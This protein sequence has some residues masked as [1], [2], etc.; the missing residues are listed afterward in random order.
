MKYARL[1]NG[2]N[3]R[4]FPKKYPHQRENNMKMHIGKEGPRYAV[5]KMTETKM[6]V[7]HLE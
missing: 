5:E 2:E 7:M 6:V 1:S 4:I 3:V